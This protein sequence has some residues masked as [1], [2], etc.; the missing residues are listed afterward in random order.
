MPETPCGSY[1]YS[2][3]RRAASGG[4]AVLYFGSATKDSESSK[5]GDAVVVKIAS[6]RPVL[7]ETQVLQHASAQRLD[8]IIPL[9]SSGK[10]H[11]TPY[12][13]L[14]RYARTQHAIIR[15]VAEANALGSA[16]SFAL[17]NASNFC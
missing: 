16:S 3:M 4:E 9:L 2:F 1:E 7:V 14:V 11:S 15:D 6:K 10:V 5:T 13:V 8:G 17:A 12:V